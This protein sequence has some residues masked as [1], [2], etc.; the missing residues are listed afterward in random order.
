MISQP[1]I[2]APHFERVQ[3]KTPA[4]IVVNG[5]PMCAPCFA[6][7]YT[8]SIPAIPCQSRAT[9]A[10]PQPKDPSCRQEIALIDST[11]ECAN[12]VQMKLQ[13]SSL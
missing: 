9:Q 7:G 8:L 5:K 6:G 10:R 12:A 4:S 1:Q 13:I 11:R 3:Q 2:R